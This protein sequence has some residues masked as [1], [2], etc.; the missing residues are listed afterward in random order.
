TKRIH[1]DGNIVHVSIT[2][3][4]IV[5]Y[6]KNL[7]GFSKIARDITQQKKYEEEIKNLLL[8]ER[9]IRVIAETNQTRL[10]K[11]IAAVNILNSSLNYKNTLT[12]LAKVCVPELASWCTVEILDKSGKLQR[13]AVEHISPEKVELAY[14]IANKYP[15]DPAKGT[16][17][18]RVIKTR[19]SEVYENITDELI[20]AN[21]KDEEHFQI[22][23]HLGIKSAII[24]PLISRDKVLGV[25][26]FVGEQPLK[27][28]SLLTK[29]L[30]ESLAGAAAIAIDNSNLYEQAQSLNLELENRV[31][32]RT[33]QLV[34]AN[35]ELEAF[36]YSVSHDLRAPLRHI[37]GFIQLLE[38]DISGILNEKQRNYFN[39]IDTSA[40]KMSSLIDD[41]LSFSIIS[42]TELHKSKINLNKIIT[43][44][45]E[46][47]NI[48]ANNN[49]IVA[50]VDILPQVYGDPSMLRQM[51]I[52]L[53]S[54]AIKFTS[55]TKHPKFKIGVRHKGDEQI[56]YIKDNGAGFEMKYADKLFGVFQ[57]LHSYKEFEGT[58]IGLAL[59]KRIINRHGGRVWAEAALDEGAT[60][61]FTLNER[62]KYEQSE[63]DSS[64]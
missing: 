42:R 62:N 24:T 39:N 15:H 2:I 50:K 5:D 48:G 45:L 54:N 63:K 52:N 23:K 11:L 21:T 16:G 25:L 37:A 14:D 4:P 60:F 29:D 27:K 31:K 43:D 58:G 35:K 3:S 51:L 40:K 59:V 13:V 12:N 18:Y 9:N 46:E 28:N 64:C 36:S 1:K 49:T 22:I 20:R 53:I 6:N 19:E 38:K 7:I 10:T 26:T 57:R 41:L 44:I 30:A 55:K 32:L 17:A 61:H 56:F 47:L 34:E 33:Q 8:N